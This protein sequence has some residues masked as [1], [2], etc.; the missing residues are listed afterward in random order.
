MG[1]LPIKVD[2][3]LNLQAFR[4]TVLRAITAERRRAKA[5]GGDKIKTPYH[6]RALK[7]LTQRSLSTHE[8]YWQKLYKGI[9]D[10]LDYQEI[11]RYVIDQLFATR[12]LKRPR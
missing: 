12:D 7:I 4:H 1:S 8:V 5:L 9:I 6:D 2:L 3:T 11:T 10:H